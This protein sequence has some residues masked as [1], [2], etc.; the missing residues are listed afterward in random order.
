MRYQHREL[1]GMSLRSS[2]TGI[3]VTNR[4]S[5]VER[6]CKSLRNGERGW[7]RTTNLL[8][9]SQLLCQL[10]YAPSMCT[11]HANRT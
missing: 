9:K 5:S 11:D 7:N 8:I 6:F 3:Y 1:E 10:S 2:M 4:I